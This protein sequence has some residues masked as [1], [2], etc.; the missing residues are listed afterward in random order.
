MHFHGRPQAGRGGRG[1]PRTRTRGWV[2]PLPRR[3]ESPA[4]AAGSLG[5][6]GQLC[7]FPAKAAGAGGRLGSSGAGSQEGGARMQ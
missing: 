2:T 4:H 6:G 3:A 5:S 1:H 7:R